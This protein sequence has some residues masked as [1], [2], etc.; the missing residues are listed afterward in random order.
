MEICK[1]TVA[2]LNHEQMVDLLKTSVL[3]TVT[4]IQNTDQNTPRRGCTLQSCSYTNGSIDGE[5]DNIHGD[6]TYDYGH[7]MDSVGLFSYKLVFK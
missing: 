1:V 7:K 2:T 4:V 6:A 5:Y 3:V